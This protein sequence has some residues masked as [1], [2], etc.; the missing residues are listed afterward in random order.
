[1]FI[2]VNSRIKNYKIYFHTEINF[3]HDF[4]KLQNSIV[5]IDRIVYKLYFE[6]K[7]PIKSND[8][9]I[10]FESDENLK[11]LDSVLQLY[12]FVINYAAKKNLT[13]V[14]IGGGILQ[15]IT[16]FF[17]STIYRGIKW[18]F[19]PTTLLAQSDSCMGSKT[20]LNY[21][22]YKNL[23]GTF[24]PPDEI[25]ISTCFLKTL[26]DLD[27]YSG[28][29]EVVKLHIMGGMEYEDKIRSQINEILK[30]NDTIL[31]DFVINSLKI[32]WS[33]IKDDEFDSGRRNLLNFGHCFGHALES[34]SNFF[35]PHGQAV[36]IGMIL[37]NI[38]SLSR[39]KLSRERFNE[40]LDL[41][42][43]AL[44]VDVK[45]EY[46]N[47]DIVISAM[48][49]DKK[50]T[51]NLLSVILLDESNILSKVDDVS[52][53]EAEYSLSSLSKFIK[54]VK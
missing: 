45:K 54:G 8:N 12:D 26:K 14:S 15:D 36:L 47:T 2:E 21:S 18:I 51:G 44:L 31:I 25:H 9:F 41:I 30:R 42:S 22:N 35:I 6:G 11:N 24:Y 43:T 16:G 17:A 23:I 28:L 52:D 4:V 5:V 48:K 19:I 13:I 49:K 3:I 29:G 46:L 39:N 53:E 33:Y 20:S 1:M 27:F 37:A 40:L 50:R 34:S 7:Y 10:L 32:K 38:I